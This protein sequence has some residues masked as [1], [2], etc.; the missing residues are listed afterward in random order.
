MSEME[1]EDPCRQHIWI[2]QREG[3]GGL[4]TQDVKEGEEREDENRIGVRLGAG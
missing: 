3:G 2:K 1:D 4:E